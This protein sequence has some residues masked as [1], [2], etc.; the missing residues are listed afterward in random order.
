MER[1]WL[2]T[3]DSWQPYA[4]PERLETIEVGNVR[5]FHIRLDAAHATL[6]RVCL[7][8]LLQSDETID[9]KRIA[10]YPL[11]SY[12]AQHW[13]HHAKYE[14][15]ASKVQDAME[16]LFDASK[17]YFAAWVWKYDVVCG[18]IRIS[19]DAL[20][21]HPSPPSP[22]A[23]PLYYATSCSLSG[24]MEYLIPLRGEDVNFDCGD[25]RTPLHAASRHGHL[26]AV[27]LSLDHRANFNKTDYY[28]Q[29]VQ[30]AAYDG[31][32]LEVMQLLLDRG[33]PADVWHDDARSISH[34]S[35]DAPTHYACLYNTVP[36]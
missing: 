27:S 3:V 30:S 32:H 24:L 36:M 6:A 16:Q 7:T 10:T 23:T 15:V 20:S 2:S 34:H 11:A 21:D 19:V 22:T 35:V 31:G 33:A 12:A 4:F 13:F 17:P 14:D 1:E 18:G 5:D 26:N 29:T 28:G 25:R 8:M 9:K